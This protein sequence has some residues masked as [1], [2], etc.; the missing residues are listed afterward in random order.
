MLI[1]I[2]STNRRLVLRLIHPMVFENGQRFTIRNGN[3]TLGTGVVTKIL[4]TLRPDERVE[5]LEG[6]KG[7]EKK[8]R[9]AAK[10]VRK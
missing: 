9:N 3:I 2:L 6:K 10:G 8:E 4:K 5:I 1:A 7:R